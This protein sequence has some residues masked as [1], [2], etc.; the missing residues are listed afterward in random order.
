MLWLT[1]AIIEYQC[2]YYLKCDFVKEDNPK[3]LNKQFKNYNELYQL[4]NRSLLG[5]LKYCNRLMKKGTITP[6]NK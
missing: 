4:I 1:Q 6:T 2:S 5:L 3:Q